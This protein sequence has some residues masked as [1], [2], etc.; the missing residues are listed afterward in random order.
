MSSEE[1]TL[2]GV[3]KTDAVIVGEDRKEDNI[4]SS[5]SEQQQSSL[6]SS[7]RNSNVNDSSP[8][9]LID[10][11]HEEIEKLRIENKDRRCILIG[12]DS[13]EASKHSVEWGYKHGIFKNDDIIILFTAWE[14]KINL[15]S[16]NY[17]GSV[18]AAPI[19]L[20]SSMFDSKEIYRQNQKHLNT[21]KHLLKNIYQCYFH[22][23]NHVLSLLVATHYNDNDSIGKIIINASNK[24]N[25]DLIIVGSRGLGKLQQ[26]FM[27]SVSNYVIK[28][29]KCPVLLIKN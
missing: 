19:V 20:P 26:F 5:Q 29:A 28:H 13:S 7:P 25:V 21:A 27:G 11:L 8:T 10:Q 3:K 18:H 2:L 23:N 4:L 17:I 12:V 22:E 9:K 15:S 1:E 24:L 14:D 16:L 6:T